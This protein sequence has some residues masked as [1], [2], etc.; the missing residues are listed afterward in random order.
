MD[1]N[2]QEIN[3][4]LLF[5]LGVCLPIIIDHKSETSRQEQLK[6]WILK[7]VESVVYKNEGLPEFPNE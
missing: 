6:N 1:I 3:Q 2:Y 7:A 5:I 4:R